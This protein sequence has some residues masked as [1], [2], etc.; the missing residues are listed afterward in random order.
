MTTL[1]DATRSDLVNVFHNVDEH[2]SYREFRI[3]NGYA[4]FTTFRAPCVWDTDILKQLSIKAQG[5]YLGDIMCYI[6]ADYLPRRPLPDEIIY[7]PANQGWRIIES[8]DEEGQY[9]LS[10][11]AHLS[12]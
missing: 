1:R 12:H 2:A 10:L 4:S 9:N 5:V 11:S 3:S 7:S 8:V 6:I